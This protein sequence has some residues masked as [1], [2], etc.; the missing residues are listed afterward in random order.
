MRRKRWT[1]TRLAFD[2]SERFDTPVTS[3]TNTACRI[4]RSTVELGARREVAVR[5]FV[6]DRAKN[7]MIR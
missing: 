3:G 4:T 6:D 7:V 1:F 2:L 5:G